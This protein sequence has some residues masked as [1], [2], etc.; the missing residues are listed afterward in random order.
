[1]KLP[2]PSLA[3]LGILVCCST[4]ANAEVFTC[5]QADGTMVFSYVPCRASTP[6]KSQPT[7]VGGKLEA[8]QEVAFEEIPNDLIAAISEIELELDRL[9]KSRE[10][11]IADAPYSTG[12]PSSLAELKSE[13]RA[14]YQIRIDQ[15]LSR[16]IELRT[17][18]QQ[19]AAAG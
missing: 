9:R 4:T 2:L 1:M 11:E 10:Q 3:L 14:S 12:N 16:L 6:K 15:K 7:P 5:K 17:R 19:R 18:Q 8:E 13:I